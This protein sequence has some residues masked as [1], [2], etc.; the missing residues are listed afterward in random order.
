M[1]SIWGRMWDIAG[2]TTKL[3]ANVYAAVILVL[4]VICLWKIFETRGQGGWKALIPFY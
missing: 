4:S 3:N 2:R 1:A